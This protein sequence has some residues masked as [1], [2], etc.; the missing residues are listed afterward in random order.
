MTVHT[1]APAPMG[2]MTVDEFLVFLESRPDEEKWSLID[3]TAVMMAP[4]TR[5]RQ[6]IA[7]NFQLLLHNH[8]TAAGLDL[9]A[10]HDS[11]VR[12]AGLD[13]FMP[14][15]DI[16]VAPGL[17]GDEYYSTAFRL[18]AEVLSPTNT[19]RLIAQKLK[20]YRASPDCQYALII[21]SQRIWAELHA[22]DDGWTAKVLDQPEHIL[23]LPAF[24][25]HCKLGDLYRNTTLAARR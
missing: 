3:G 10:D 13:N 18:A 22:R 25:F 15:P 23:A 1:A 8:F 17:A 19:T 16:V 21:D 4:P 24:G 12:V 11:G 2:T 5:A 7:F 14:Q 9:F 20:R 6:R